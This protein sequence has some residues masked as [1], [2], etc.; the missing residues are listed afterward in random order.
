MPRI[1]GGP[2]ESS[3]PMFLTADGSAMWLYVVL[4]GVGAVLALVGIIRG[5][6][7]LATSVVRVSHAHLVSRLLWGR[8]SPR[9]ATVIRV[10]G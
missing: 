10:P 1:W 9:K 5:K 8:G 4:W 2:Y 6:G 3:G 7:G